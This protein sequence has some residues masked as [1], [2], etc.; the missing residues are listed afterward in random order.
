MDSYNQFEA[1]YQKLN[2]KFKIITLIRC[3]IARPVKYRILYARQL[4]NKSYTF[5]EVVC[6]KA[7]FNISNTDELLSFDEKACLQC[8]NDTFA[9]IL[10]K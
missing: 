4:P 8:W 10:L 6:T 9:D 5:Y 7:K 3:S 2:K 1:L